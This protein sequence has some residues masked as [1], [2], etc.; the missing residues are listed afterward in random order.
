MIKKASP[1]LLS[2]VTAMIVGISFMVPWFN[3]YSNPTSGYHFAINSLEYSNNNSPLFF[4]VLILIPISVFGVLSIAIKPMGKRKQLIL[5]SL[6]LISN[7]LFILLFLL[8][9]SGEDAYCTQLSLMYDNLFKAFYGLA[10]KGYW[11]HLLMSVVLF[12]QR[13]I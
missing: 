10:L 3:Y 2:F 9:I 4:V 13:N 1:Y 12:T 11:I 8:Q 7:V 5:F 6:P